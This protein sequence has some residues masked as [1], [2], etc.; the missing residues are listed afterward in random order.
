MKQP[1]K[2]SEWIL[3]IGI[4]GTFLGHGIAALGVK[5]D[6]IPLITSVGFSQGA[7]TTLLPIIGVVDIVIAF[8]ALLWPIRIVL[9]YAAVWAFV[10]ALIQPIAGEQIWDFVEDSANW[11]T[12]LALLAIQGFP[13]K[14]NDIFTIR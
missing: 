12:P 4:L 5:P 13:K 3:R 14:I 9:I 1:T 6:W 7:A 8:L 10:T 2:I 11:A